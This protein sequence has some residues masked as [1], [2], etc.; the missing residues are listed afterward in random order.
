M[1]ATDLPSTMF[2]T[3]HGIM[4]PQAQSV[5]DFWF[6]PAGSPGADEARKLWFQKYDSTDRDIRDRFGTLIEQA[7]AGGLHAWD[8]EGPQSGLARILLLDQFTRNVHRDTPLAFAGDH[9]ALQAA[10]DM[11]DAD[12]DLALPP[13]QRSFVYLPFE[14]AESAAM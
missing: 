9:L 7:L 2:V 13:Y 1:P 4:N 14:H 5:F 10:Q 11:V 12:E 6:L 3:E 8:A